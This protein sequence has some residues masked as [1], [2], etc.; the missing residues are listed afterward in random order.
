MW[1]QFKRLLSHVRSIPAT[2]LFHSS[3][4][5]IVLIILEMWEKHINI[6]AVI[7]CAQLSFDSSVDD[8]FPDKT[9]EARCNTPVHF[10]A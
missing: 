1:R 3:R 10:W 5:A 8:I 6:D 9:Q 7:A 4:E 2:S